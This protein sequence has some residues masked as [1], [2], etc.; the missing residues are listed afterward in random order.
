MPI[1][2]FSAQPVP[3]CGTLPVID[4]LLPSPLKLSAPKVAIVFYL[5]QLSL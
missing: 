1:A 4:A 5:L 3:V 2:V